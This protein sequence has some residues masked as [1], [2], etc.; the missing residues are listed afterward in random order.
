MTLSRAEDIPGILLTTNHV[1]KLYRTLERHTNAE[2]RYLDACQIF[3][4]EPTQDNYDQ[5]LYRG[6]LAVR[7]CRSVARAIINVAPD[8]TTST[9][10]ALG[11]FVLSEDTK[12]I[13]FLRAMTDSMRFPYTAIEANFPGWLEYQYTLSPQ[14]EVIEDKVVGV[15]HKIIQSDINI[16]ADIVTA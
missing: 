13:D 10:E 1:P 6:G 11:S 12:R 14:P 16:L 7:N 8:D 5:L 2:G 3:F 15:V 9:Q 4:I